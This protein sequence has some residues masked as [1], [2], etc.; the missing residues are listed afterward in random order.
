MRTWI[1]FLLCAFL[2]V[3]ASTRS[4]KV[5]IRV[6]FWT[7]KT[8]PLQVDDLKA[9]VDG[10]PA[11]ALRLRGPSDDL[12][13]LL[14]L[15]LTSD[16]NEI[17]LAREALTA[18]IKELPRNVRIGILRAQDGLRVLLD[19]TDDRDAILHTIQTFPVSG[20][21]ELIGTIETAE[22][23][24]DSIMAKAPVRIA[25]CYLTDSNIYRYRE[26]FTNPVINWSDRRDLSRRFPEGL[27]RERISK[28][29][30]K[31]GYRQT[32]IFIIHLEYE[33]DRLNEAYQNGLLQLTSATGGQAVFCRS[34][35]EIASVIKDTF[36]KIVSQ[37]ILDLELSHK[38]NGTVELSLEADGRKLAYRSRFHVRKK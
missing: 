25:L 4:R 35:T 16:L 19:P 23:L 5:L 2:L 33:T 8:D 3:G 36:H 26:D 10:A 12:M 11:K 18:T 34:N 20:A 37:Y 24:A 38:T 9:V 15:D 7:E 28:L 14:I 21:P 27:V 29:E 13:I 17:D 22:K 6:P 31:L 30:E 1:T 32:P